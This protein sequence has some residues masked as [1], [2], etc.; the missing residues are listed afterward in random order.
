VFF[1]NLM[2]PHDA[3]NSAARAGLASLVRQGLG[4]DVMHD[5]LRP[6]LPTLSNFKSLSLQMLQG[7]GR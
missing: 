3:V 4:K 6:I 2:S 1:K 5:A 7:L